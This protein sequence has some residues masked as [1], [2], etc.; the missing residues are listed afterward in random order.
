MDKPKYNLKNGDKKNRVHLFRQLMAQ[1]L[2]RDCR[3]ERTWRYG[4]KPGAKYE[5]TLPGSAG[6]EPSN[7]KKEV[8]MHWMPKCP[9]LLGA[10][11][12][13]RIRI[14]PRIPTGMDMTILFGLIR[15]ATYYGNP[16]RFRTYAEMYRNIFK[17]MNVTHVVYHKALWDGIRLWQQ[18]AVTWPDLDL[19]PPIAQL[20]LTPNVSKHHAKTPYASYEI[21]IH[22]KWLEL[23]K[24]SK[25]VVPLPLPQYGTAQNIVLYTMY[26]GTEE[27]FHINDF[28]FIVSGNRKALG[29]LPWCPLETFILVKRW[30]KKHKGYFDYSRFPHT[31]LEGQRRWKPSPYMS[32]VVCRPGSG[33]LASVERARRMFNAA[34]EKAQAKAVAAQASATGQT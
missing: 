1:P 3:V 2:A 26:R 25:K 5:V 21:T 18:L 23:C 4:K 22:P 8:I 24:Q 12:P 14:E 13:P 33:G 20:K 9:D 6:V 27:K 32:T 16:V 30:Y 10:G 19:P 11:K 17:Q 29:T 7:W 28:F 15:E 34:R 31:K